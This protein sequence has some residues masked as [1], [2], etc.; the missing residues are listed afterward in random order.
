VQEFL[1]TLVENMYITLQAVYF[2]NNKI[3][4]QELMNK[5]NIKRDTL[6][7]LHR[8]LSIATRMWMILTV[9][10]VSYVQSVPNVA[11]PKSQT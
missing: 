9:T 8:M 3:I 10:L 5:L 11:L 1:T 7:L 4:W 2:V 6:M